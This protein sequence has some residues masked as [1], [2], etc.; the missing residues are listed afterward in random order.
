MFNVALLYTALAV[1]ELALKTWLAS[2]SQRYNCLCLPRAGIK[3]VRGC[4][5]WLIVR[6]FLGD[7]VAV[8]VRT[9]PDIFEY[10][11]PGWGAV[12]EGLEL[13]L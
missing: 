1:L 13:K 4:H 7:T 8:G 10:L 3:G 9:L 5:L 11:I 12:E 2:N 6:P